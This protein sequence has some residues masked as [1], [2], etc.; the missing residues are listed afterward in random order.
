MS[1]VTPKTFLIYQCI[2]NIKHYHKLYIVA[3]LP[4]L[5]LVA[6]IMFP[7][8]SDQENIQGRVQGHNF[9]IKIIYK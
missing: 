6:I 4:L 9:N 5:Q 7:K 3:V 1:E 8:Y 2:R